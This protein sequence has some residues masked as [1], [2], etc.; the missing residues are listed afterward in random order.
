VEPDDVGVAVVDVL[1]PTIAALTDEVLSSVV[2]AVP[3]F[4]E[5]WGGT[6]D[7]RDGVDHGIRGFLELLEG[8]SAAAAAT[9]AR[10]PNH[11]VFFAFGRSELRAGRSVGSA[12][13]AYRVG[14]QAAWRAMVA[15]GHEAGIA[16]E[17]LYA[18][19]DAIFAYIDR[20]CAVTVEGYAYEQTQGAVQRVDARRRLVE[21]AIRRPPAA[22]AELAGA[23]ADA[24][25]RLPAQLAV[26]AFRDERSARVAARLGADAVVARVDGTG[27]ALVPDPDGP[28]RRA[29][30]TGALYGVRAGVG[31]TVAPHE[32][33]L[34]ARL[35]ERALALVSDSDA[36][37]VRADDRGVDLLLLGDPQLTG[38]LVARALDEPLAVVPETTRERLVETL[39]V[40]LECQGEVRPT[41]ERLH[42]HTQTVRYRVAQ[43]RELL[44]EP[45]QTAE[46]RLELELAVRARRLLRPR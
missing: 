32:A 23:A 6:L 8:G 18:V 16:P 29:A 1:R 33:A 15:R 41:A 34:S 38:R 44:G 21:L 5:W 35:A 13:A 30:T 31:P 17:D 20:L 10:L 11:D 27:W 9:G 2:A 28:G 7:V 22:P 46:G 43:L 3:P 39:E 25:W 4:T 19:A 40:W 26:V 42:V 24:A 45:L 36:T 37:A 12:L 14:A